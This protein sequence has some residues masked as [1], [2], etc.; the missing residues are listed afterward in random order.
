MPKLFQLNI[1]DVPKEGED[2]GNDTT[3]D[4]HGRNFA[5]SEIGRDGSALEMFPQFS[6]DR[7]L[8]MFA[9]A[10]SCRALQFASPALQ[11]DREVLLAAVRC[12]GQA[13]EVVAEPF[14]RDRELLL[15]ALSTHG[16][17]LEHADP[18]FWADR[19]IVLAAGAWNEWHKQHFMSDS[20]L[21]GTCL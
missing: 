15:A 18:T 1:S 19:D 8:V 6:N 12:H 7:E 2:H 5:R 9:C 17:A 13:F 20:K 3:S 21:V 10:Q 11:S 16:R 4:S 14:K